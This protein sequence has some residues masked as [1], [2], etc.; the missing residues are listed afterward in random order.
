[1]ISKIFHSKNTKNKIN[2]SI[3]ISIIPLII[4]KLLIK[5]EN[6]SFLTIFLLFFTTNRK[7]EDIIDYL[8]LYLLV[9]KINIIFILSYIIVRIISIFKK[10]TNKVLYILIITTILNSILK[11]TYEITNM[12][13]YISLISLL[14][15]MIQRAVK[16]KIVLYYLLLS[17]IYYLIQ[18]NFIIDKVLTDI[19]NINLIYI[20]YVFSN[21]K[22]TPITT[23]GEILYSNIFFIITFSFINSSYYYIL[24]LI[25]TLF[26]EKISVLLDYV[27]KNK[28]SN[29]IFSNIC[30]LLTT[31]IILIGGLVWKEV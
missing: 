14:Y 22:V 10:D 16:Y 6:I 24:V 9:P 26:L 20:V 2:T 5:D 19:T 15:L 31:I 21:M 29:F 7:K 30:I 13:F 4:Y 3:I 11:V 27:R 28:I 25:T 12:Y 8:L 23:T 18:D 1:M 17:I